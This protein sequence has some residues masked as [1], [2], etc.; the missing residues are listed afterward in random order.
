M[1]AQNLPGNINTALGELWRRV[2]ILEAVRS[3]G[4]VNFY[5]KTL[6]AG[7][8]LGVG[9]PLLD[10]AVG[11]VLYD[12]FTVVRTG[13]GGT[14]P[15][16]Y[17]L[18]IFLNTTRWDNPSSSGNDLNVG[19]DDD[20]TGDLSFTFNAAFSQQM[21]QGEANQAVYGRVPNIV[22]TPG[23]LVVVS[24]DYTGVETDGDADLII[25]AGTPINL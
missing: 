6:V 1:T 12:A 14:V 20:N 17:R 15:G 4:Q 18:R 9:V 7:D 13:F 23:T 8:D 24:P 11:D 25:L 2:Q 19:E 22:L 16:T 5:R 21:L 3:G 10:V